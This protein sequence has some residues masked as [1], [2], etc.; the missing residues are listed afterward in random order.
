MNTSMWNHPL[1][2]RHLNMLRDILEYNIIQPIGKK[3]ACGDIGK[4]FS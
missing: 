2:S 3:L 4:C 1:T